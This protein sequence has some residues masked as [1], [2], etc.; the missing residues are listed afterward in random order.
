MEN[1]TIALSAE[2]KPGKPVPDPKHVIAMATVCGSIL[3]LNEFDLVN[4][5]C[6]VI[7]LG[8]LLYTR[9]LTYVE[10]GSGRGG[11]RQPQVDFHVLFF[12]NVYYVFA[13]NVLSFFQN[14]TYGSRKSIFNFIILLFL[15]CFCI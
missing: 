11:L 10:E 4:I 1:L 2:G 12:V 8:H 9:A 7:Y 14:S 6:S 15:L 3:V 5:V 13:L